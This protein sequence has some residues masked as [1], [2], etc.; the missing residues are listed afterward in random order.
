MKKHLFVYGTLMKGYRNHDAYIKGKYLSRKKA[1]VKGRL[2]HLKK[3]GCPALLN[4]NGTVIGELYELSDFKETIIKTDL[5]ENYDS[6]NV[7]A[8][9]YI[10]TEIPVRLDNGQVIKADAYLYHITNL[11]EF[12]ERAYLIEDELWKESI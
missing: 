7:Y 2:Y 6:Q 12:M 5:L 1:R 4:G 8:S 9:Q 10:R 3:C 11:E